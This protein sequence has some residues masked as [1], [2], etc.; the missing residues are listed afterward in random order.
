MHTVV[1]A[2]KQSSDAFS[3]GLSLTKKSRVGVLKSR[4]C[5]WAPAYMSSTGEDFMFS[6]SLMLEGLSV[7]HLK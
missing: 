5:I 3:K 4:L 6:W 1:R 2:L 7:T